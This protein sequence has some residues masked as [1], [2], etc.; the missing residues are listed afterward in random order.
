MKKNRTINLK[1]CAFACLAVLL[2]SLSGVQAFCV[3]NETDV[4]LVDVKQ[5]TNYKIFRGFTETLAPGENRCCSW[6]NDTCNKEGKENSPTVFDIS[7]RFSPDDY[8]PLCL[9]YSIPANGTI[10]VI[11][12]NGSYRCESR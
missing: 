9:N 5:K 6:Q 1:F 10:A 7:Y 2:G 4:A 8:H 3:K 12:K 11:G